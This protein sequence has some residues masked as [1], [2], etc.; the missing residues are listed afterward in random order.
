MYGS[1]G[2]EKGEKRVRW[3]VL[4]GRKMVAMIVMIMIVERV[5]VYH[6]SSAGYLCG[7]RRGG[8]GF[9]WAGQRE[10]EAVEKR[11]MGLVG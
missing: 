9:F 7:W 5:G 4:V 1:T 3:E 11:G 6:V 2:E 8:N 10:R